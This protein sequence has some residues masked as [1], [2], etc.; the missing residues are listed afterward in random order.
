VTRHRVATAPDP[1]DGLDDGAGESRMTARA[2]HAEDLASLARALDLS[3]R[4]AVE[5]P[6][7]LAAQ[8]VGRL[9]ESTSPGIHHM[10]ARAE[11]SARAGSLW[12][13]TTGLQAVTS[14]LVRSIDGHVTVLAVD[15]TASMLVGGD[16]RGVA[17][18]WDLRARREPI[19]LGG[20]GQ[21]LH[22][23][24]GSRL[25]EDGRT[26][27]AVT[28]PAP[29]ASVAFVPQTGC[30]AVGYGDDNDTVVVFDVASTSAVQRLV[31]R[32][33]PPPEFGAGERG[34]SAV[35]V[36][37]DGRELV[38]LGEDGALRAWPLLA[39]GEAR[40]LVQV[41]GG[42]DLAV[43]P[44]G[45]RLIVS[46]G[47]E[48]H[49]DPM[50]GDRLQGTVVVDLTGAVRSVG[51]GLDA[52]G[53]EPQL[54]EARPRAPRRLAVTPDGCCAVAGFG[55]DHD[56]VL[57]WSPEPDRL[58]EVVRVTGHPA[59]RG[60]M[61]ARGVG[62]VAVT[63]D[64]TRFVTG[65]NDGRLL[66]WRIDGEADP[67]GLHGHS[68]PIH[69]LCVTADGTRVISCGNDG[70]MTWDLQAATGEPPVPAVFRQLRALAGS[71][72]SEDA[73]RAAVASLQGDLLLWRRGDRWRPLV[74]RT[75]QAVWGLDL[76]PDG[77]RLAAALDGGARVWDLD[78]E[79]EVQGG[80]QP[81]HVRSVRL[82]P[83]GSWAVTVTRTT[84]QG[85]QIVRWDPAG[86]E[87]IRS[88]V[89]EDGEWS[90]VAV[91]A[92]G[93][94]VV[95]VDPQRGEVTELSIVP[96]RSGWRRRPDPG[97]RLETG[98]P[99]Y[100]V[101]A[102]PEAGRVVVVGADQRL[103]IWDL[104]TARLLFAL[105][106]RGWSR[107]VTGPRSE[108]QDADDDPAR[109][110]VQRMAVTGDGRWA[111]T[112]TSDGWVELWDLEQGVRAA[113]F[114]LDTG[115]LAVAVGAGGR[116]VSVLDALG[117]VIRLEHRRS[118]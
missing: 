43:H 70:I 1:N 59:A 52:G 26:P 95:L 63:P 101:V 3:I 74:E 115:A 5:R 75:G 37:I 114:R 32:P 8:L 79:V 72:V 97:H 103:A 4:V 77:S 20:D 66:V 83:D 60:A 80:A 104:P 36:T 13:T 100:R 39:P 76:T 112:G 84:D 91:S 71:V 92:D 90:L 22:R 12:P 69:D 109:P 16:E 98:G 10:V 14:P 86:V 67:L 105:G 42:G 6:D 56:T 110:W 107:S 9:L 21:D 53:A 29:V 11:R 57:I 85:P 99:I 54:G 34:V 7:H 102:A 118:T 38:V 58:P 50:V 23:T 25:G 19:A 15:P 73:G 48:R 117:S 55:D 108:L 30:I 47:R 106:T 96:R 111:A 78:A 17:W 94:R 28:E 62:A 87:P 27:V 88:V 31:G 89:L 64:G 45:D 41:A 61:E 51:P 35:A 68:G 93:E 65:H 81:A 116:A 44:D 18:V 2:D 33:G 24:T 46:S 82:T 113:D 49:A 40:V